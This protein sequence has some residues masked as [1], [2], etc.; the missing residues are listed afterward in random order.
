MANYFRCK[1]IGLL[2]AFLSTTCLLMALNVN[3]SEQP[4]QLTEGYGSSENYI[5]SSHKEKRTGRWWNPWAGEWCWY[6]EPNIMKYGNNAPVVVLLHGFML[7][8]PDIY[9]DTIEHYTRQGYIVVFPQI[10]KG[11]IL[12]IANDTDQ[13]AM[14]SRAVDSVN[15]A[16]DKLGSKVKRDEIYL[17]GHS[18]GGLI[19]SSWQSDPEAAPIRAAVLANP[20]MNHEEGIPTFVQNF[21][22]ITPIDWRLKAKHSTVPTVILSGNDDS[23]AATSQSLELAA[24][25]TQVPFVHVYQAQSDRHGSPAINADHMAAINNSG[26]LPDW[27]MELIGGAADTD[28]LD[29]G[30]YWYAMDALIDGEEH[31]AFDL[32][33]WSNGQAIKPV[34]F[35]Y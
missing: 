3:A 21:I 33:N 18:L 22:S 12:G 29:Y 34:E 17:F 2:Q 30:Y 14:L 10:N 1:L 11:G 26:F 28:V 35:L 24:A 25:Y 16:L 20:Q 4:G 9:D 31:M 7:M 27:I 5:A 15:D 6:Y 13:N 32:G 8:A 23:L 19:G